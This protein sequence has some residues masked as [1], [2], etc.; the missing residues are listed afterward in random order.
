MGK[1]E[2]VMTHPCP[3]CLPSHPGV[4]VDVERSNGAR[5]AGGGFKEPHLHVGAGIPLGC[6][7]LVQA[8]EAQPRQ[9][10]HAFLRE[11]GHGCRT[12]TWLPLLAGGL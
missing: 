8:I 9:N 1:G 12:A 4:G 7:I 2:E 3:G 11:P 6:P 5:E 10:A